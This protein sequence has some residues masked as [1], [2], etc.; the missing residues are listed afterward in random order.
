MKTATITPT[1]VESTANIRIYDNGGATF[2]RFTVV[3]MSQPER[4]SGTFAA[5]GMSSFPF[6]PQ[7]FGQHTTATPGRHLCKRIPFTAL[8]E[9]CQK[10]TLQDIN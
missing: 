7:G 6:H 2:D 5:L 10:C 9:D 8:P 3:F 1:P 4:Q